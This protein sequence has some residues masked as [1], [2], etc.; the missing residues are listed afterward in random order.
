MNQPYIPGTS[1]P[2]ELPLGRFLPPIPKGMV[3]KWCLDNLKPG[4]WVLEPFGFSPL[5]PIEIALAGH[6]V[7]VTVNNPIH[8]FIL[9][10]LASAPGRDELIAALQDLAITPKGDERMETYIRSLYY[11]NCL[12]CRHR[13]EADAFLW[14]KGSSFPY[15]AQV[16]CPFCGTRGEQPLNAE[17]L[18]SLTPLPPVQLHQARALNR[19]V[20]HNDPL[21]AQVEIALNAYPERPIV[22]LQ[23]I[24]NKFENLEQTPRRRDLLIALILSAADRG[25]TLWAYPSPRDRPRQIVVPSIYRERNLWKVLEDAIQTWQ[26]LDSPIPVTE[27]T[28]IPPEPQ[29]IYRYT[30]RIKELD[31]SSDSP[32]FAC[33]VTALPRPNQAFWTL[34]AL[35]TG[36]IW[37][38]E[39][40]APIRQVLSRQRY[41]WNWHTNALHAVF[42]VIKTLRPS[43]PKIWG[44][45]AENEPH[46]LLS[47]LLANNITGYQL[48]AFARS[49][50]DQLA[51]C[52]WEPK[53]TPPEVINPEEAIKIAEKKVRNY[54]QQKGEPAG[55]QQVHTAAVTGLAHENALAM[56]IFLQNRHQ[57]TSETQRWIETLFEEGDLLTRLSGGVA[58]LDTGE[59]WLA[60]PSEVALPLIDR[61]EAEIVRY[62][63]ENQSGTAEAIKEAIYQ[64]FPGIYTPRD[65]VLITCLESYADLVDPQNHLWQLRGS[66]TASARLADVQA[67][68]QSLAHI[69]QRLEFQVRGDDPILWLD[70]NE[71]R[72]RFSFRILSSAMVSQYIH[73][74][75]SVAQTK[76]LVLPGSRA[77]LLAFKEQRDPLLKQALEKDYLIVKFRLVRDL[78]VNP[79]LSRKLFEELIHVDPPEY[80]SSQLA[81][82]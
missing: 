46:L 44:V 18:E 64:T 35:W 58:A 24:I 52:L 73:S 43:I 26:I 12:V 4:D 13:I 60:N 75:A 59:W 42:E 3:E 29:G 66:E 32:T 79:L 62:L 37:G 5:V 57:A 1:P 76:I 23:T 53:R 65:A 50:N 63:T 25:N 68:K 10:I 41:D 47:A 30:G 78:E 82:F 28:G 71:T 72:P 19:I 33:V 69:A 80:Q 15:A 20:D 2:P 67:I 55:Y 11:V 48:K 74:P 21:R 36:W 34:S 16:D 54:L 31:L 22:V 81:L 51:Q 39:A 70:R 77:N 40:V 49:H 8:A 27:W 6:P 45:I 9:K 38:K 14:K 56:D 7:L 17:S 61:V